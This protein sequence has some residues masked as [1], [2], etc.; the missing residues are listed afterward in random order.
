M[1][2]A[3]VPW[4]PTRIRANVSPSGKW[5]GAAVVLAV[6]LTFAIG[7]GSSRLP[8]VTLGI[9]LVVAGITLLAMVRTYLPSLVI[10]LCGTVDIL[11]NVRFGVVSVMGLTTVLIAGLAWLAWLVVPREGAG[12]LGLI[13]PW[14]LYILWNLASALIWAH[15]SVE[16][17]QNLFVTLSFVGLMLLCASMPERIPVHYATIGRM[18]GISGAIAA[19]LYTLSPILGVI[20]PP[21]AIQARSFALF[22]ILGICWFLADSQAGNRKALIWA[23]VLSLLVA[24]SLS[25]T[26]TAVVLVLFVL[27]HFDPRRLKGWM[28]LLF[29][30]LLGSAAGYYAFTQVESIR[31]RFVEGDTSIK[32]GGLA[33]NGEGRMGMWTAT[34]NSFKESPWLGHGIGTSSALIERL[35]APMTHP[36]EDYLRILHDLGVIGLVIWVVAQVSL[37]VIIG[38]AWL[39]ARSAGRSEARI[40]Q[41]A[42]LSM[43]GMCMTMVTDNVIVYAFIMMPLAILIGTS[44]GTINA[45]RSGQR[46]GEDTEEVRQELPEPAMGV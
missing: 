10:L 29:T 43:L 20:Y 38:R 45:R 12:A 44:L 34:V 32:I 4:D 39:S 5:R 2:A 35:Y 18:L 33:I 15:P 3:P 24:A 6:L 14:L 40:H 42:V 46:A 28:M 37:F 30:G 27:A 7:F 25:R 13:W 41:A 9:V 26:A 21:L 22:A 16:G 11:V 36:H 8:I 1:F 17:I 19:F 23:G 31:S